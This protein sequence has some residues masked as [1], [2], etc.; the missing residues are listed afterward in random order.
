MKTV[1]L[2][3]RDLP[4]YRFHAFNTAFKHLGYKVTREPVL[5]PSPGMVLVVWNRQGRFENFA[6]RYEQAG[7]A[8]IV[9]ENGYLGHDVD[10]HHLF[11]L[12]LNHHNGAGRWLTGCGNRWHALGVPLAPWRV[13]GEHV[14]V[15]PQRGIGPCG[16]AMPRGWTE[17]VTRRLKAVT[18]RPVRVREHPGRGASTPL[19]DDLSG[20]WCA[21]TWGSTAALKAIVAGIPVV[22][23]FKRWIGAGAARFGLSGFDALFTEDRLP[24]LDRLAWAQWTAGEIETGEPILRLLDLHRSGQE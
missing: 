2:C 14:I 22:H 7:A 18:R 17:C 23:D 4:H 20:A 1:A 8:V 3:L 11:A 5:H 19:E 16:V 9:V 6:R 10:G 24:M 15:L 12:A 13:D 21:I